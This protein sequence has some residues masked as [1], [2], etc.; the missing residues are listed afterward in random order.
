MNEW[1]LNAYYLN[2]IKIK[3]AKPTEMII[4][5]FFL[6]LFENFVAIENV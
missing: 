4:S 3:I 6:D 1:M 5:V 2:L